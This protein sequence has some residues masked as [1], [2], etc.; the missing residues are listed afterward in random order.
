[1]G[2]SR[3]AEYAAPEGHDPI[4]SSHREVLAAVW[5]GA[6]EPASEAAAG[7]VQLTQAL[8]RDAIGQLAGGLMATA[9]VTVNGGEHDPGI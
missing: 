2:R 1:M 6:A 9:L 7:H 8:I 4:V 3:A 5:N